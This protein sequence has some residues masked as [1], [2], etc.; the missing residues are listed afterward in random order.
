MEEA[1]AE[2][3]SSKQRRKVLVVDDERSVL[4][5]LAIVLKKSGYD[6]TTEDDDTRALEVFKRLEPDMALLDWRMGE[7]G[8]RELLVQFKAH[9]PKTPVLTEGIALVKGSP[10]P[11][12]ARKFYEFVTTPKALAQQARA[13]AKIPARKDIDKSML[14]AWMVEQT[15][16]PMPIDWKQFA[17]NEKRWCDRWEREVFDSP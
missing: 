16:D 17:A 7:V 1:R 11:D 5:F 6:V 12:L 8:G 13:H 9:A 3:R 2:R 10:N 14:P 15:I 4:E